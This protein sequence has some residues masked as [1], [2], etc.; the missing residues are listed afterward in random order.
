MLS[1]EFF[2]ENPVKENSVQRFAYS[3]LLYDGLEEKATEFSKNLIKRGEGEA[4]LLKKETS[5]EVLIKMMRGNCDSLN[6]TLLHSKILEQEEALMPGIIE[7]LKTS[8]NDVFIEHTMKLI[9][10]ST[11]NYCEEVVEIID[12][13][14]SPYAL[15]LACIIIGFMGNEAHIPLLLRK[16]SELKSLYPREN[17][18]QGALLGLI[19]LRE[20]FKLFVK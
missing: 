15:S 20:R 8:G 17:Y 16:H 4:E 19:E 2:N 7:K 10:K 14:R 12:D 9:K 6:H 13:I 1:K 18:E 11:K 3:N 5:P